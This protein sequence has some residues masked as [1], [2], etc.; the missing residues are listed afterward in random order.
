MKKSYQSCLI[1][2][3]SKKHLEGKFITTKAFL[4]TNYHTSVLIQ[5]VPRKKIDRPKH[6]AKITMLNFI[7]SPLKL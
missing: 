7:F 2:K 1:N 3:E 5:T 4:T 6:F